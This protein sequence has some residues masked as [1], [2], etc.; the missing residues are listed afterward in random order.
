M[1]DVGDFGKY[2]LLRALCADDLSLGVVRYLVPD[3]EGTTDSGHIGFLDPIPR[4]LHRF[5]DCDPPLYDTLGE[6]VEDGDRSVRAVRERRVLPGGTVFY[7]EVLSFAGMPSIG[8]A[9]KER[10]LER[11]RAWVW[12]A[13]ATTRG[14]DV[15]F[16]D[17]DNGLETRAGV[18]RHRLAGPKYAYFDELAPYLERS[19][20]LVVYH[21]LHRGLAHEEQVRERLLQVADRLGRSFALLYRPYAGRAFF[22]VPS[23]AHWQTL[24]ERA[25]RLARH[26]C[27]SEHFTLY[28]PEGL[29]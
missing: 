21:H 16:A 17:P 19:R 28:G 29:A 14:C 10:R 3:E 23:D 12:D 26:R 8:R 13:L 2:G 11:R 6:I 4:N 9:A 25:A 1:A 5:R 15:V 27:W 22:V 18:P 20:S 7:E 24:H